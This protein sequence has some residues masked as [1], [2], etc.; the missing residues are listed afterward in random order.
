MCISAS[1]GFNYNDFNI[2]NV[3]IRVVKVDSHIAFAITPGYKV[4]PKFR[5]PFPV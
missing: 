3:M 2:I 5:R 4:F 1:A